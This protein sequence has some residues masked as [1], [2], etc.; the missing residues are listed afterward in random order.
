MKEN[1]TQEFNGGDTRFRE[2]SVFREKNITAWATCLTKDGVE[3]P[4]L[5][6]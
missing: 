3:L 4:L 5:A 6:S 2:C 1:V